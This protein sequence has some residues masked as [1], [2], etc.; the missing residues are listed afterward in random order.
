MSSANRPARANRTLLIVLGIVVLA[1]GAF[2]LLTS[3]G[4]LPT[5]G[6]GPD[7]PVITS[8]APP[9]SW[10][11]YVVVVVAILLGLACLWYLSRQTRRRPKAR[12]WRL[13]GNAETGYTRLHTA[14]AIEPLVSELENYPGVVAA[15]AWLSGGPDRPG[16]LIRLR[17]DH[18]ADLPALREEIHTEAIP[19]LRAA[20][21]LDE[22]PTSI[23]VEPTT[24]HIRA[25]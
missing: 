20:L 18:Q 1:A 23:L 5:P 17:T 12:T 25:Q 10:V 8:G 7:R 22:V 19:R 24:S 13:S 16:L 11:R 4:V 9:L 21:E 14:T 15:A 6:F 2:S 3:Y